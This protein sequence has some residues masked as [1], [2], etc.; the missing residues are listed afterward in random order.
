MSKENELKNLL[1]RLKGEIRLPAASGA[2]RPESFREVIT[3]TPAEFSGAPAPGPRAPRS[4]RSPSPAR[5]EFQR[6]GERSSAPAGANVV[7][8]ENKEALLFGVLA[9]LVAIFGGILAGIDY[10]I[11]IGSVS[12]MLF[13][14]I[15]VLTLFGYY[16]NFGKKNSEEGILGERVDRL[17][18]RLEAIAGRGPVNQ[19]QGET[20]VRTRDKEMEQK[21]DELRT[22][23]KSLARALEEKDSKH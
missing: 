15:M 10:V 18:R 20:G 16:L 9:S 2:P 23:V 7:W 4:E 11:L 19:P 6:G 12:F 13:S 8:S 21:V 1:D 5:P 17:S 3:P 22:L 14:F